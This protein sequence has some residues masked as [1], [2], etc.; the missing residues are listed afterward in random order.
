MK[1]RTFLLALCLLTPVLAPSA[2]A[3]TQAPAQTQLDRT[4]VPPIGKTP[5]LRV[6]KWTKT[7]LSNGAVP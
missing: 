7:T 5:E 2:G 3:Q 6:P 4:K 1:R